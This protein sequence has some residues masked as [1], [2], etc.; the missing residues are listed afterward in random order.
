MS[1]RPNGD[2]TFIHTVLVLG[3]CLIHY[4]FLVV[5]IPMIDGRCRVGGKLGRWGSAV[6][7][8]TAVLRALNREAGQR[9]V[10]FMPH[11]DLVVANV[12][13]DRK[14]ARLVGSSVAQRRSTPDLNRLVALMLSSPAEPS[15]D[16]TVQLWYTSCRGTFALGCNSTAQGRD[17]SVEM[18]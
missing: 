11:A 4:E 18:L 15:Y 10:G 17:A 9:G 14:V 12:T 16:G 1:K 8:L 6:E 13:V 7:S 5:M 3:K 2:G